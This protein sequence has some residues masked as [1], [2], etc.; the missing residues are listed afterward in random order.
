MTSDRMKYEK[1]KGFLCSS[2]FHCKGE[3]V[4]SK[5]NTI[6]LYAVTSAILIILGSVIMFYSFNF[7]TTQSSSSQPS[8]STPV[9][10]KSPQWSGYVVMSNLLLR[11]SEVTIV[12]GSWIVP[13]V[14][15]TAYD[16]YSSVWVGVGGYGEGS[17]IQTG[18]AQQSVKGIVSYYAWYELLPNRAVRIQNFTVLPGD[19]I[20][21]SV[22]LVDPNKNI[23]NV[24]IREITRGTSFSR[25]FMYRSSR[26]SAEWVVEA[27]S[28]SGEV[29]TLADFGSVTFSSGFATIA[30]TTGAISSFPGYQLVMYD[31]QDVQLVDVSA[32]NAEGSGFTVTYSKFV[33]NESS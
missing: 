25:N 17:L 10:L 26:L 18:T 19:E 8:D 33:T 24:E 2:L 22:K 5:I 4:S 6:R 20:T 23:W 16:A 9:S 29:T 30:N 14:D 21:A 13:S 32:L 3:I 1:A 31:S 28:I 12:T 7:S 11:E 27:P 15:P